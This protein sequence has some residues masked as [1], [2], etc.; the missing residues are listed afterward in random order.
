MSDSN[1]DYFTEMVKLLLGMGIVAIVVVFAI[2]MLIGAFSSTTNDMDQNA[3]NNRLKS[4][5]TVA[6][7]G[8]PAP[9]EKA[10]PAATTTVKAKPESVPEVASTPVPAPAKEEA[11]DS[12]AID[13]GAL[14]KT[15]CIACHAA[16]VAGAPVFGNKAQ[17]AP[18]I[19][20]GFDALMNTALNGSKV[21][22]A[23][24]PKGGASDLSD[25]QIKAIVEYMV[26]GSQ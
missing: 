24:L 18:R 19:A 12:A 13:G 1:K 25:A 17:W 9:Q 15:K 26:N 8:E 5:E 20:K 16:G 23:M 3:V 10:K 21:N 6:L 11:S 22:P 4:V 14:Y 2:R 7:V